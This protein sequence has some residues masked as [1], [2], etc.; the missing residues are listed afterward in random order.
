[1]YL[2]E[3]NLGKTEKQ[4]QKKKHILKIFPFLFDFKQK[5]YKKKHNLLYVWFSNEKKPEPLFR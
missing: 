4:N 3:T 5:N 2:L 1:M